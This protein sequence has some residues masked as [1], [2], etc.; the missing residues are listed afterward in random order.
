MTAKSNCVVI[1]LIALIGGASVATNV[2]A[3]CCGNS[4]TAYYAPNTYSTYYAPAAV[5]TSG[6]WYPGQF[7][8]RLRM[9]WWGVPATTSYS[10]PS[11]S[12]AYAPTTSF[13][14]APSYSVGYAPATTYYSAPSC[15]TC[16]MPVTVSEVTIR[17]ACASCN[18]CEPCSPCGATGSSTVTQATYETPS[19]C[20]SCAGTSAPAAALTPTPAS[21]APLSTYS[22][23]APEPTPSLPPGANVP[24]QREEVQRQPVEDAAGTTNGAGALQTPPTPTDPVPTPPAPTGDNVNG[25]EG[26]STY[27]EAPQLFNPRDRAA[28]YNAAPVRSAVLYRPASQS[29][30]TAMPI[31]WQ[32]AEQDAAGW[33]SVSE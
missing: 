7:L 15:T 12:V 29:S 8:D 20:T 18:T 17:P 21:S 14:S 13:Y 2:C 1:A 9:A 31:S 4:T 19:N 6:G 28:Q 23:P 27:L 33:S 3:Q 24:A 25:T 10:A 16:A 32:Q 22:S 30:P 5:T 26:N 11:Y